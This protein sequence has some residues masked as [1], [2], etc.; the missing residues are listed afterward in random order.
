MVIDPFAEDLPAA[1]AWVQSRPAP[2]ARLLRRF[3]P[4]CKVVAT[5]PLLCPP[6]GMVGR[7]VSYFEDGET[8]SV[9]CEGIAFR[10][11]CDPDW[12]E[13]VGYTGRWTPEYVKGLLASAKSGGA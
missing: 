2:V 12:L 11:R 13:V 5:R 9:Q 10:G 8:V 4:M 1:I 7:V 3:P 6:P